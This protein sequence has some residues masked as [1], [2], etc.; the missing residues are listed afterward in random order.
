MEA[1][2]PIRILYIRHDVSSTQYLQ[3]KLKE[4][5]YIVDT[6]A[7][8]QAGLALC[9]EGEYDIVIIDQFVSGPH[10]LE[11]IRMLLATLDGITSTI[12]VAS[13]GEEKVAAEAMKLGVSDFIIKDPGGGY[14][15]LLDTVI[16]QALQQRKIVEAKRQAEAQ[17]R[18]TLRLVERAKQEWEATLDSLS[19]LVCLLDN[20][21]Q[22][23]RANR[24]IEQW[25]LASVV[26]V[27]GQEFCKIFSIEA[28]WLE[29][30]PEVLQG[31]SVEFEVDH[32]VLKR[33]LNI[34]IR[35]LSDHTRRRDKL[36]D[37]FAA[38][39]VEDISQRK[40]ADQMLRQH[41]TELEVRNEELDAFAYMVAHDL[42]NP[43]G[44]IMGFAGA[45]N[46]YTDQLT[47][48]ET[49]LYLGRIVETSH[50]MKSI[51]A[52]LLLLARV[53]QQ[54]VV[55]ESLDME[56]LVA[57]AISRLELQVV[58]YQ[59]TFDKPERWPVVLG[60][61]P[62]V[63]QIWINYLSNGLKYGGRPPHLKLGFTTESEDMVR[64]WVQDNGAGLG[65]NEQKRLFKPFTRLGLQEK[66]G[67]GLGLAI[68]R[69][70]VEKLGGHVSVES[71][72]TPGEGSVFSFT[73]PKFIEN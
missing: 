54:E 1:S 3:H 30:W 52:S 5:G 17:T 50:K 71:T 7:D 55:L 59:A 42:Q 24:T 15:E 27:G 51:L 63:E 56:A 33:S 29:F 11:A 37:S 45:L 6:A 62:W 28:H 61:A 44:L 73:L 43:L 39:V 58:E 69:R 13:T 70:I 60:F 20:Q 25:G 18:D 19:H 48:E 16:E 34:Q 8:S 38:V 41:T 22:I 53:R 36:T 26:E 47:E 35:P 40:E 21:G 12:V 49:G 32:I 14:L 66:R 31:R 46:K 64:F 2:L 68:V 10:G 4:A 57:E 65:K 67:Q 23:I 72:K 9:Q